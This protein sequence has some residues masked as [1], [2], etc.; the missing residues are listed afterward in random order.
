MN[1][2]RILKLLLSWA[3]VWILAGTACRPLHPPRVAEAPVTIKILA[4]TD[5]HGWI[6]SNVV[7]RANRYEGG[8]AELGAVWRGAE[9]VDP[10]AH[11]RRRDYLL[12]DSG[13][14]WTGPPESTLAQGAPLIDAYNALGYDAA[15]VG[16]HEFD[17]TVPVLRQHALALGF[18]LL[19][20]NLSRT[21]TGPAVDFCRKSIL[22]DVKG[23]KV[24][25]I[26]LSTKSTPKTTFPT[27]VDG[28]LFTD[29]VPAV[30]EQA[31]ALMHEGAT[32]LIVIAHEEVSILKQVADATSDLPIHLF[33]G[34]H[35]HRRE[36]EVIDHDPSTPADDVVLLN[37]GP[38][39]RSYGRIELTFDHGALVRH[40]QAIIPV[41]GVLG[42][43]RLY[44]PDQTLSSIGARAREAVEGKMAEVVGQARV[45]M[46]VGSTDLSPLGNLVVDSW[47]EQFPQAELAIGNVGGVRQP[48][49]PGPVKLGDI[50][51]VL[52]FTNDL[53]LIKLTPAQ[54]RESLA[55]GRPLVAGMR[56][57][58]R[59]ES[60]RRIVSEVVGRDGHPLD[61]GRS[62]SVITTDFLQAGGDG[63]PFASMD[64]HPTLL[65]VS[66]R[67]PLI[68]LFRRRG[69]EGVAPP[70]DVRMVSDP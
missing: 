5:V 41:E 16:N 27:H 30:R 6:N 48:I 57:R 15:A 28:L 42:A 63:L 40:T 31:T 35:N 65:G 53:V 18:P 2:H 47:L 67:D 32:T 33:L 10:V 45:Q 70:T 25:V 43:R 19:S 11:A 54:I 29:L 7:R 56:C 26:G 64:P 61:E 66:W 22:F 8:L 14:M 69:A 62:Y 20:A 13:D 38:Y 3:A 55:G 59:W 24:G 60:G 58:Y 21:A 51:G 23:M 12:L 17:F 52:P 46:D 9:G 4:T 36:L 39:A 49:Q 37:A 50:F 68:E 1:I 34:G 44:P